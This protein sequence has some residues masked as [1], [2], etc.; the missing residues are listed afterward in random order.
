MTV[1]AIALTPVLF[2]ACSESSSP[3]GGRSVEETTFASTLG[4][5]LAASTRT[6]NGVFYRDITVGT[7]PVVTDGQSVSVRYTGYLSGGTSF[8]T[9]VND[10]G[11]YTFRLGRGQVIAGW[12]EG[13]IGVRVGGTRQLIIPSRMGYGNQPN[14]PIPANSV[15]VFTV[16]V[17]SAQ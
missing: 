4:V 17:I 15:L 10:P 16:Q 3:T 5:N 2:A 8:G 14:G 9:N 1:F 11:P 12:D 13:L 6:T 7:G